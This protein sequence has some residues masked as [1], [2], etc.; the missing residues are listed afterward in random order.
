MVTTCWEIISRASVSV[1]DGMAVSAM[2]LAKPTKA[3]RTLGLSAASASKWPRTRR[4]TAAVRR[5]HD[6][7][8]C[9]S[10]TN[11]TTAEAT[12]WASTSD[13]ANCCC[14]PSESPGWSVR[15]RMRSGSL[16]R[17]ELIELTVTSRRSS[18]DRSA[19]S[20]R[21][22]CLKSLPSSTSADSISFPSGTS[23]GSTT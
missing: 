23:T 7:Q 1:N 3:S 9:R 18:W 15:S 21:N 2:A 10:P 17:A 14:T 8:Y 20:T 11:S 5:P 22:T 4:H 19:R 12:F 6:G 16:F 13:S